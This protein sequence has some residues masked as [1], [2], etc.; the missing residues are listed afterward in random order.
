M[1]NYPIDIFLRQAIHPHDLKNV[2]AH[3]GNGIAEYRATL[4]I[5]IMET[6]VYREMRRWTYRATCFH[7][8]IRK[9]LSVG[10]QEWILHTN[11]LLCC[12]FHQNCSSPIPEKHTGLTIRVVDQRRHLVGPYHKDLLIATALNHRSGKIKRI[13]E[14]TAC[15]FKVES[16]GIFQP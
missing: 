2:L 9:A 5:E 14:S 1:G 15:S 8:E 10:T 3:A 11:V 6:L 7:V 4:L 13:E 16:K 12:S